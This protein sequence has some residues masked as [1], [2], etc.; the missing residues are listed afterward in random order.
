MINEKTAMNLIDNLIIKKRDIDN[1]KLLY[2][3]ILEINKWNNMNY[4][5]SIFHNILI[6]KFFQLNYAFV[7]SGIS[8]WKIS[9]SKIEEKFI[10]K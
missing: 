2:T 8:K 4:E 3:E 9:I 1:W 10:E 7:K 5:T 6:D